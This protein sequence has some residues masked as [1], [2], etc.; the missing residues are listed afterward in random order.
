MTRRPVLRWLESRK[1]EAK[2]FDRGPVGDETPESPNGRSDCVRTGFSAAT[3][4]A[5]CVA[6]CKDSTARGLY[7]RHE[8]SRVRARAPL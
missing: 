3:S 1:L 4:A 2:P 8:A 5:G 6:A 7:G